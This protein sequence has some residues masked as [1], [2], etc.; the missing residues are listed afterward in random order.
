LPQFGRTLLVVTFLDDIVRILSQWND[1]LV[2]LNHFQKIPWGFTHAFLVI[3]LILMVLGSY[4]A[5]MRRYTVTAVGMLA[6]V[7]VLQLFGYG[8]IYRPD[9]L[10]RSLSILGAFNWKFRVIYFCTGGLMM[11]L[12]DGLAKKRDLFAGLP[13]LKE[14]DRQAY[15]ALAGRVLLALLFISLT[16]GGEMTVFRMAM[17]FVGL[18]VSVLVRV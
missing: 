13:Q 10:F 18:C 14:A 8:L 4:G 9:Y 1:Q 5:I 17:I 15:V 7:V 16:F 2:Y 12:S 3:N 11:L 6:T